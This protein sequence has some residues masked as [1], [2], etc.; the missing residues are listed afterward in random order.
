MSRG[1]DALIVAGLFNKLRQL[2]QAASLDALSRAPFDLIGLSSA[3]GTH[4]APSSLV[5]L[6]SFRSV[7]AP[8][9]GGDPAPRPQPALRSQPFGPAHPSLTPTWR[10]TQ[11]APRR[12]L[13]GWS[14]AATAAAGGSSSTVARARRRELSTSAAD[15]ASIQL[16]ANTVQEG[17]LVEFK[18]G[19]DQA[20]GLVLAPGPSAATWKIED[21]E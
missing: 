8:Q 19:K 15:V 9:A 5:S 20:L 17:R 18:R 1:T 10:G 14:P 13:M 2:S 16:L 7:G 11:Q 6:R 3:S 12:P 4:M 21:V